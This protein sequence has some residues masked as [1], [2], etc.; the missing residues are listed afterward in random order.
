MKKICFLLI[1]LASLGCGLLRGEKFSGF[2]TSKNGN[3][4][5][6]TFKVEAIDYR[7]DLIRVY[8]SLVGRPHTAERIDNLVLVTADGK[9]YVATDIEGVDFKRWFQWEDDGSIAVEID[10]PPMKALKGFT[11]KSSGPKGE[12]CSKISKCR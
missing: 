5:F 9:Q 1:L 8:G 2:T 12:S 10:F 4:G 7:P 11:L 3:S 6:I